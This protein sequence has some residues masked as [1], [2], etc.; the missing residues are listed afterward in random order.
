MSGQNQDPK[1][2]DDT[3]KLSALEEKIKAFETDNYKLREER[4]ALREQIDNIS[5]SK[6]DEETEGL[7]KAK[8]FEKLAGT[9]KQELETIRKKAEALESEK[10]DSKKTKAL[11]SELNKYSFDPS[12][13]TDVLS[14]IDRKQIAID[15]ETGLVIG[16]DRVAKEFAQKYGSF[17]YFKKAKPGA[18]HNSPDGK[19]SPN[20][21]P[22][23]MSR[24]DLKKYY[25]NKIANKT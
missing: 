17:P 19:S 18:N 2:A 10:K 3:G 4:R 13:E 25:A 23:S 20:I 22:A 1:G 9:Y 6:K 8:E 14:L 24:E 5:R 21:D 11:I 7:I 12:Y 16:A 15:D